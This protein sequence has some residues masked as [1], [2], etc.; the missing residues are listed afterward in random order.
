MVA[1]TQKQTIKSRHPSLMG[2]ICGLLL[3]SVVNAND[4]NYQ[5]VS[6][7]MDDKQESH[8]IPSIQDEIPVENNLYPL[9]RQNRMGM[10]QVRKRP[11][12]RLYFGVEHSNWKIRRRDLDY[13]V[14][15][16]GSA[17]AIGQV[18]IKELSF[19]RDDNF[20]AILGI[21]IDDGWKLGLVYSNYRTRQSDSIEAAAG[22]TL[23]AT[24]SHPEF[25]ERA[26]DA[27][28]AAMLDTDSFDAEVRGDIKLS[29]RA[30]ITVF[31][32][33]RWMDTNQIL[34]TS[35][36]GIDFNDGSVVQQNQS[37]LFGLRLGSLGR[38]DISDRYYIF[39]SMEAT[40]AYGRHSLSLQETNNSGGT[41]LV[42]VQDSYSQAHL[43]A[44]ASFGAGL[45]L[46]EYDLRLGYELNFWGGMASRLVFLDDTHEAMFSHQTEDIMLDGVF[47]RL[48]RD[49]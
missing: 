39:G 26:F 29:E 19:D 17:L 31:G 23:Y 32:G 40:L 12:G 35:Y 41:L 3:V 30:S 47:I 13:A 1:S 8:S 20:K 48:S 5:I 36:D 18:D 4:V 44:E 11:E 46:G 27:S 7:S 6:Y 28:M 45:V 14:T 42:D 9:A 10:Q 2:M 24:R 15:N 43:L 34:D 37:A 49:Y 33:F 25:N 21:K 38:Y 16:T 22:E